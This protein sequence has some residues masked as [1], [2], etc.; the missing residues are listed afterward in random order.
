MTIGLTGARGVLGRRLV[1]AF[2]RRS[3]AVDP[4]G[5]DVRDEKAL[6]AWAGGCTQIVHAAAVVPTVQVNSAPGT[7]IAVNVA[8]TAN[9]AAAAAAAGIRL[10]YV[11]TSHVYASSNDALTVDAVVNPISL[12]GLTK[13]QGEQWIGR[14]CPDPLIVRLFSYFDS[15]QAPSF[16]IP[17]LF[18]RICNA[19]HGATLPLF[20]Y[21]SVRDIADAHWLA[22]RLAALVMAGTGGTYNLGTGNGT[23]IADIAMRLSRAIGR[24]DLSWAPADDQPGDTLMACLSREDGQSSFDLDAALR[25][26]VREIAA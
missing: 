3:A 22:D 25:T 2:A 13:W 16:L 5:G 1:D 4:F 24:D 6:H 15:R 18:R 19:P 12:Y 14:L 10:T 9:V 21:R 11:S 7:A 8:G 26:F 20:G 23:T 17:A